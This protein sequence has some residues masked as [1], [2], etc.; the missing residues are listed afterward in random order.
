VAERPRSSACQLNAGSSVLRRTRAQP[1][2]ADGVDR[3]NG[4][5]CA[6]RRWLQRSCVSRTRACT[7]GV[8]APMEC[9]SPAREHRRSPGF[10]VRRMAETPD[11]GNC[12]VARRRGEELAEADPHVRWRGSH[13]SKPSGDPIS[14]ACHR[15][16][17]TSMKPLTLNR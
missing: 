1:G 14:A 8:H 2:R 11:A 3:E 17:S 9:E 12:G 4:T 5:G 7:D 10:M 15:D 13:G 16:F 6:S